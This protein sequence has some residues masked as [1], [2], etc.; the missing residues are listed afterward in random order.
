MEYARA[1]SAN[2]KFPKD[3]DGIARPGLIRYLKNLGFGVDLDEGDDPNDFDLEYYTDA[4]QYLRRLWK[5]LEETQEFCE[6][7][8]AAPCCPEITTW[9]LESAVELANTRL[10][11]M[12][13]ATE[14]GPPVDIDRAVRL[15]TEMA[16]KQGLDVGPE[17]VAYAT[18]RLK[19]KIER[20]AVYNPASAMHNGF[21]SYRFLKT[22]PGG[23]KVVYID[24]YKRRQAKAPEPAAEPEREEAPEPRGALLLSS[25]L[26]RE[27]PPRDYLLGNIMSTTS[28]WIIYGETGVGKTLFGM[29]MSGAIASGRGML[30]WEGSGIRRRVMYLDGELPAETFKER[31]EIVARQYG[32]DIE[33]YG[34]CRD[35]LGDDD[36]P[37]LNKPEGAK[38]LERECQLIGPDVIVF[39]SIMCLLTGNMA[40][41]ESWAT[42]TPM[43]RQL[44]QQRI[45]QIWLHHTGHD[46]SKG[47]GT[48]TREW[49]MDTVLSLTKDAQNDEHLLMEF[50]KARLR[51][52]D[53]RAQFEPLKI[54][55]GTGGW[56]IVG[57]LDKRRGPAGDRGAARARAFMEAY[58]RL[59]C[60]V[61]NSAGFNGKPV[62]KVAL[63]AI[64]KEMRSRGALGDSTPGVMM[65]SGEYKAFD[66]AKEA[67]TE[68]K[69]LIEA[70][71]LVWR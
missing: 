1:S 55:C 67:N 19:S 45:A 22:M 65:T 10:E 17:A 46:T 71:G 49:Q 42:V 21:L 69:R 36:I 23:E 57:G 2:Y 15:G 48:K 33:L 31:M 70:D 62:K 68:S 50:K 25:W 13:G 63:E 24:H 35:I 9:S 28:R 26:K 52:P 58:D 60:D 16:R 4:K 64:R 34:Y 14:D 39:D 8:L 18:D 61:L 43:L 27:L 11:D 3:F 37:P 59:A 44:S 5:A 54:T 30:S 41:E 47:F 6:P 56:E 38:W 20:D 40:E 66:R 7:G 51:T 53:T 12:L 32:P 29:D